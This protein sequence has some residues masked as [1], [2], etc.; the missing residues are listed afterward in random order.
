MHTSSSLVGDRSIDRE[1]ER[2]S[3]FLE[4]LCSF[5]NTYGGHLLSSRGFLNTHAGKIFGRLLV[6]SFAHYCSKC[7]KNPQ[8]CKNLG[9]WKLIGSSHRLC[10]LSISP[11]LARLLAP[12][13]RTKSKQKLERSRRTKKKKNQKKQ[14]EEE[15]EEARRRRRGGVSSSPKQRWIHNVFAV[16]LDQD[17]RSQCL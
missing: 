7:G 15:S 12:L 13:P 5:S 10:K 4:R 1:R 16:I 17:C 3:S 6:A 2:E 11:T 14:E 9:T 8:L